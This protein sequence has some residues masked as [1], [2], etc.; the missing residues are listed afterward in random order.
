MIRSISGQYITTKRLRC[1][2]NLIEE[3][4]DNCTILASAGGR[5]SLVLDA[6]AFYAGIPFTG[7]DL[8]YA[9]PDVIREVSHGRVRETAIESLVEGGRLQIAEPAETFVRK[10]KET[11][12]QSGDFRQVS[13]ADL[14]VVALAL[15]LSETDERV[16][17]I[18]DDYSVQ[19]LASLLNI[20]HA[21]IM[22]RGITKAVHWMVYCSGCGKVFQ[23]RRIS[24]CD[25]CGTALRRKIKR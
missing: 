14:S 16:T 17:I 15:Q 7:I 23:D 3:V 6:T 10:V 12:T 25:V 11:A 13:N 20:S 4:W 22:T 8:Y 1:S 5:K 9:T 24:I 19:N 21:P 2:R 18:S